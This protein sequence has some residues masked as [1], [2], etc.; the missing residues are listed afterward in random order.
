MD[1]KDRMIELLKQLPD[2]KLAS[3]RTE[4]TLRCR[5]CGDSQR[6]LSDR[7]MYVKLPDFQTPMF[8]NCYRANC[9]AKGI[10]TYDKLMQWG[11]QLT[12]EDISNII[13]YNKKMLKM[14]NNNIFRD[15][16][17]YLLNNRYIDINKTEFY[18]E[19]INYI[20]NRIGSNFTHEQLKRLK[21]SLDIVET[22]YENNLGLNAEL[23]KLKRISEDYIGF[24]TQD[25]VYAVCRNIHYDKNI[26]K[27]M[28]FRYYKYKFHNVLNDT[29]KSFY[30]IPTS[31]NV[32][33]TVKIFLTE[34]TFDILSVWYNITKNK[35]DNAI[36]CAVLGGGYESAVKYFISTLKIVNI[37]F[38]FYID[39]D[40]DINILNKLFNKLLPYQY[41][42]FIHRNLFKE[43]KDFGVPANRI[44]DNCQQ[45]MK[46]W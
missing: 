15:K 25:N 36:Y 27:P 13:E 45:I 8:Y 2:A 5:Y 6:H 29:R 3:G 39:N 12:D 14:D 32:Y 19:K 46:G 43:E 40:M 31:I 42:I 9:K 20:N 17:I 41:N 23:Y 24:I 37:E 33:N 34:G 28:N 44:I 18:N 16:E 11:V 1:F 22:I 21:I 4:I 7:H 30:I 35:I 10:V 26:N 38:H